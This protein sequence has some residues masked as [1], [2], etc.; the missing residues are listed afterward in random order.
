MAGGMEALAEFLQETQ[1]LP[2]DQRAMIRQEV[3]DAK[4]KP[5]WANLTRQ[6]Q[7]SLQAAFNVGL[8]NPVMMPPVQ[9]YYTKQA[10][11]AINAPGWA[12]EDTAEVWKNPQASLTDKVKASMANIAQVGESVRRGLTPPMIDNAVNRWSGRLPDPKDPRSQGGILPPWMHLGPAIGA[13]VANSI[14]APQ[15]WGEIGGGLA[16]PMAAML[17]R[18][19]RLAGPLM[20]FARRQM[21]SPIL[22]EFKAGR[23]AARGGAPGAP[24]MPS[25]VP[26]AGPAIEEAAAAAPRPRVRYGPDE[27]GNPELRIP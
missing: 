1:G 2:P 25:A 11:G 16:G 17:M 22:Q 27:M 19:P 15:S 9:D 24:S 5:Q 13:D 4:L 10:M 3:F 7:L 6:E 20:N 26:G 23:A 14:G 12:P 21:S 18:F 8:P